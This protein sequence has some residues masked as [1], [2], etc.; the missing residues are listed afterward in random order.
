MDY[1]IWDVKEIL[2]EVFKLVDLLVMFKQGLV[3]VFNYVMTD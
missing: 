1:Y 3:T 2:F